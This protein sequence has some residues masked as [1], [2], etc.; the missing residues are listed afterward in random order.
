MTPKK[1]MLLL[2]PGEMW[3]AAL[4]IAA[5]SVKEG[6]DAWQ[7]KG[8]CATP[9]AAAGPSADTEADTCDCRPGCDCCN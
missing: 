5:I 8:C 6:R 3:I 9:A 2:W 7:A 1:L 4:I